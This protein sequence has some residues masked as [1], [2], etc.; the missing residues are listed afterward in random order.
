MGE[1]AIVV[2]TALVD[3]GVAVVKSEL[4]GIGEREVTFDCTD[5]DLNLDLG[6]G[7]VMLIL[8]Q[9]LQHMRWKSGREQ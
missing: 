4:W 9:D 5:T 6:R 2:I 3:W 7:S 8:L 1:P